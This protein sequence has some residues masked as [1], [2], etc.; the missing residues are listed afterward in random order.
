MNVISFSPFFSVHMGFVG[1]RPV[2]FNED[3][4]FERTNLA[5][6]HVLTLGL[7]DWAQVN[8]L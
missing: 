8:G 3:D 6:M 5:A 2:L 7:T 1:P 4:L